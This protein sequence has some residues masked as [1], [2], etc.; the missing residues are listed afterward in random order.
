[1]CIHR[2]RSCMNYLTESFRAR[3]HNIELKEGNP[4]KK[5]EKNKPLF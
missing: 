1:M 2:N 5:G 4:L 3:L